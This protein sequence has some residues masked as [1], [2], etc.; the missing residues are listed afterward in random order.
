MN[1]N[2]QITFETTKDAARATLN[3]LCVDYRSIQIRKSI[4]A[5]LPDSRGIQW[6]KS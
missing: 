6:F 4:R 3:G 1:Y 2:K 5:N